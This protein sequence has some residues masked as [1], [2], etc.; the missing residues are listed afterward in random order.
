MEDIMFSRP[1]DANPTILARITGAITMGAIGTL[2]AVLAVGG[3][4]VLGTS[5]AKAQNAGNGFQIESLFGNTASTFG[6]SDQVGFPGS[7]FGAAAQ[8]NFIGETGVATVRQQ[9]QDQWHTIRLNRNYENPVVIMGPVADDGDDPTTV[10]IRQ[11]GSQSFEFQIAEW[12]YLDGRHPPTT[13]GYMV[14]EAGQHRLAD[15]TVLVAGIAD[16]VDESWTPVRFDE[17]F[18]ARPV[19]LTSP[20]AAGAGFPVVTRARAVERRGFDLRL[21][22]EEAIRTLVRISQ[23]VGYVAILQGTGGRGGP[24]FVATTTNAIVS[25]RQTTLRVP[26]DRQ[27]LLARPVFLA[28][29][30]TF[31][32]ADT[33]ALRYSTNPHS[34]TVRVDEEQSTNENTVHRPEVIGYAVFAPGLIEATSPATNRPNA[35]FV[36]RVENR[37]GRIA[38]QTDFFTRQ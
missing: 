23:R 1:T 8:P 15:G 11:R 27:R 5:S 4:N 14:V 36:G 9:G 12:S 17:R 37:A 24:T 16:D 6:Q 30:Q 10:A 28:S 19:V 3:I 26:R 22:K 7:G 34:I 38:A 32:D 18:S 31:N 13:V 35:G 33:A 2:G 21:Q 25:D 20:Y 29:M